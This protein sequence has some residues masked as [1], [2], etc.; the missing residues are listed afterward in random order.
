MKE[1][2]WMPIRLLI[3]YRIAIIMTQREFR[4][5]YTNYLAQL[6]ASIDHRDH[7]TQ[8]RNRIRPSAPLDYHSSSR[9]FA[10]AASTIWNDRY[11][12]RTICYPTIHCIPHFFYFIK[13][14]I[15]FK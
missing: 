14:L 2:N 9:S 8:H 7:R 13:N 12:N 1:L 3:K 4:Q 6:F 5:G 10:V 11:N 15:L